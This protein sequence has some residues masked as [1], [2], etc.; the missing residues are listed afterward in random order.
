MAAP[1][2]ILKV[3]HINQIVDDYAGAVGHL[4]DLFGGQ[5]LME[6]GSNPLTDL[7]EAERFSCELTGGTVTH[8]AEWPAAYASAVGLDIGIPVELAAATGPGL[9]QEY[10]TVTGRGSGP[11]RS[12]WGT[13]VRLKPTS[14]LVASNWYPEIRR[15]R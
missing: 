9:I 13:W 1:L 14:P 10:P 5:V 3:N 7:V 4:E 2:K 8:R 15:V 11:R 6:I 12:L